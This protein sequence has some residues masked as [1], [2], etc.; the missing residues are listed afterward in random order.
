MRHVSARAE[1]PTS[2][3]Q[4]VFLHVGAPKTGTTYLQTVLWDHRQLL[5]AEHGLL[6]PGDR[7]DE[8]FFAAVD[9]QDQQFHGDP[10]PEAAGAWTRVATQARRWP[11]TTIISHEVFATATVEQARRAVQDLAPAEVHV[12]YTARDL[13]RQAPSQWQEDVK[14]GSTDRFEHWW[15][16]VRRRDDT[17]QFG[18]WFW[19]TEDLPDVVTRWGDAVGLDR[20]HL[21][22]VPRGGDPSL[23]WQRFCAVVGLDAAV[24][25]P[26]AVQITNTGLGVVEVEV[27][28]RVNALLDGRLPPAVHQHLVKGVLGHDTLARRPGAR[29]LALPREHFPLVQD[30][31]DAGLQ[32]LQ[33]RGVRVVGDLGDL[34]PMAS[35]GMG[36]PDGATEVEV[37]EVAVWALHEVLLRLEDERVRHH[38]EEERSRAMFTW[39]LR[40][41]L[42]PRSR[43]TWAR[44]AWT[45][46][47][48][49]GG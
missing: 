24:V 15:D 40:R 44:R 49:R 14:H 8:H 9:L 36:H 29:R 2:R 3:A 13:A 28:R 21:V 45:A 1:P 16:G 37:A 5:Q 35:P 11:G 4:R 34:T 20:F 27:V 23:L 7:Y 26:G 38:A 18:R 42:R 31:S 19:R 6:Y 25:D 10:R 32:A 41:A 12:L 39:R 46:R 48:L 33:E 43:W 17:R 22:T 47:R 30:L